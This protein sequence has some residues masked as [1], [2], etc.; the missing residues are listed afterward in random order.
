MRHYELQKL[1]HL[2]QCLV[3]RQ[4]KGAAARPRAGEAQLVL[5]PATDHLQIGP[6]HHLFTP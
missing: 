6:A 3:Q 4:T 5:Q 1:L 2:V